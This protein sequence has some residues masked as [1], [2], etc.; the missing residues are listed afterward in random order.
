[1]F[2]FRPEFRAPLL[3]DQACFVWC[4]LHLP[5]LWQEPTLMASGVSGWGSD[6]NNSDRSR[7]DK[8]RLIRLP[9]AVVPRSL[10]TVCRHYWQEPDIC[11]HN[12]GHC[13]W[14]V[15]S[16]LTPKIAFVFNNSAVQ[17]R[18]TGWVLFV[19]ARCLVHITSCWTSF[20]VW[21]LT[22]KNSS[23]GITV[24][25]PIFQTSLLLFGKNFWVS[26]HV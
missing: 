11:E 21:I 15:R 17:L 19:D 5:E 8:T 7:Y 25:C 26:W 18:D 10:L 6:Y 12:L 20:Q 9:P 23:W 2:I 3:I 16:A 24:W 1:M 13:P 22:H 14:Q 4:I